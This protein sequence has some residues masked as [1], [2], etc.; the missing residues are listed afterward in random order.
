M[1]KYSVVFANNAIK[2][3][4]R[5]KK[6]GNKVINAKIDKIFNELKNNPFEGEGQAEPLKYNL[7]G[8]WSRRINREHRMI[9][10]VEENIVTVFVVSALGHYSDK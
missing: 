6:A 10:R 8:L 9:Y 4:Q 1:G 7:T 3:L 5:H 2:E